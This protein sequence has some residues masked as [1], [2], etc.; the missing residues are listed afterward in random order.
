[1]ETVKK[2]ASHLSPVSA[3]QHCQTFYAGTQQLASQLENPTSSRH[4]QETYEPGSR[5]LS[6]S[7]GQAQPASRLSSREKSVKFIWQ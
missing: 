5:R 3:N 2:W 4:G 1:M 6:F 7:R